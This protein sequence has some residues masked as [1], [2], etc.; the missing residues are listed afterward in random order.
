MAWQDCSSCD[1]IITAVIS[2]FYHRKPIQVVYKETHPADPAAEGRDLCPNQVNGQLMMSIQ[3]NSKLD[4][5][6]P[7]NRYD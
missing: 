6:R 7:G 5:E 1:V 3:Y 4:A 2:I